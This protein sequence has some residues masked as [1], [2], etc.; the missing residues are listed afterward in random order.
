MKKFFLFSLIFLTHS[1]MGF[2]LVS[3]PATKFST[4]E[5]TVNVSNDSCAGAGITN[6]VLLDLVEEAAEEYWS[7][8]TTSS[9]VINKGSEVAVSI[10]GETSIGAA[11]LL[12]TANTIIVGC[13]TNV[14]LFPSPADDNTLGVG[15]IASFSDGSVRGAFLVNA[16][17][18]F[19]NQGQA[20]KLATIAHELGHSLGLG[21]S[22]DPVALMYFSIGSKVQ[23]R[24]TMDDKDGLTY[25]YPNE[26]ALPASCG[27]IAID[28]DK[29]GG[30]GF[31]MLSLIFLITLMGTKKLK[32]QQ[33]ELET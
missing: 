25:L 24:L 16:N 32:T 20:E 33:L 3:N 23:E 10:N 12:T 13:S 29:G 28:N 11:A 1:T 2:T 31:L 18:N 5:I 26:D 6:T 30:G 17:G 15:G 4:T 22:S 14:T 8:V 9:L 19:I 27:T 7:R 21:H